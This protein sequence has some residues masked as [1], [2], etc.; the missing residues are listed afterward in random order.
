[1]SNK[2][3]AAKPKKQYYKVVDTKNGHN[4]FFYKV[5]I[6]TDPNPVPLNEISSCGSGALYFIDGEHLRYWTNRGDSIAWVTPVGEMEEDWGK[7]RAHTLKVTKILPVA[8]ALPLIPEADIETFKE[9]GVSV[10]LES[11]L[12]ENSIYVVADYMSDMNETDN[13]VKL[14]AMYPKNKKLIRMMKRWDIEWKAKNVKALLKLGLFKVIGENAVRELFYEKEFKL[15]EELA[16][17][18]PKQ[19]FQCVWGIL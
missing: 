7:Y 15:L 14:L 3:A 10:T 16:I 12:K 2:K 6:N 18:M 4:G 8:K 19:F 1:M 11:I 13:L 17:A 5:G 9:F